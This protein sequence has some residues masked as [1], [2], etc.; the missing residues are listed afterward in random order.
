MADKP[1][2]MVNNRPTEVPATVVSTGAADA[3]KIPALASDGRLDESLLPTGIGADVT[4][5]P[6]SESLTAGDYV[7]IYD[8]AGV[9]SMRK[10]DASAANAGKIAD[11]FVL[12]NVTSGQP[13]TAYHSGSNTA[14]TGLT[15]GT[16]YVL[17][18]TTPGGV[19]ALSAGTTTAGHSLQVVGRAV[20]ADTIDTSIGEPIIR[21]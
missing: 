19:L 7:N 14:L 16:T 6:A 2:Q 21:G 12:D 8:N 4:V 11:G 17:S 9:T 1:L 20:A 13:A 18:H 5:A 10:A 15:V 3:G